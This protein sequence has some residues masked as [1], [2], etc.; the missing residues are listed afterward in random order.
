MTFKEYAVKIQ[1]L[2]LSPKQA[3][4]LMQCSIEHVYELA[5]SGQ[6]CYIKDGKNTR[7]KPEDLDE[8]EKHHYHSNRSQH[9]TVQKKKQ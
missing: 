5:K 8:Y 9:G 7:F 3:A 4:K 1:C 6:I 2:W